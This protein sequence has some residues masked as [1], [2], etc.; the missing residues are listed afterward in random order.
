[1]LLFFFQ[2]WDDVRATGD[3]LRAVRN[4]IKHV[5]YFANN[6][7]ND[8]STMDEI[9]RSIRGVL[10]QPLFQFLKHNIQ[11]WPLDSS[12]LPLLETYLCC[13]QPWRYQSYNAE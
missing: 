9:R 6:V 4:L 10:Q 12:F 3:H 13:I 1:M 2:D 11:H 5:H 8:G 7:R